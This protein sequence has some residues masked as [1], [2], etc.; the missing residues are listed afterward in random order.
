MPL[1]RQQ[2]MDRLPRD[3]RGAQFQ[4][5]PAGKRHVYAQMDALRVSLRDLNKAGNP[6][7]KPFYRMLGESMLSI[8]GTTISRGAIRGSRDC[9]LRAS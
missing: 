3:Y 9:G 5:Q 7:V 6:A 8:V 1:S 4:N 2:I